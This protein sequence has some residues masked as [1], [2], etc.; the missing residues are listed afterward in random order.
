MKL[1][2]KPQLTT[3]LLSKNLDNVLNTTLLAIFLNVFVS[4][5][6]FYLYQNQGE[7]HSCLLILVISAIL[8]VLTGVY[9][10]SQTIKYINIK[11]NMVEEKS[12][13]DPDNVL[14]EMQ[15]ELSL[16]T[17]FKKS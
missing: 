9:I 10:V 13:L 8:S 1:F 12:H 17:L 2:I 3:E 11:E 4:S 6:L 15:H 5:T 14:I 7:K 16:N